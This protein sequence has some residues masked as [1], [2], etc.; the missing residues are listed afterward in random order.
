MT[1]R[2]PRNPLWI[3]YGGAPSGGSIDTDFDE[4]SSFL[5]SL[6]EQIA[7][8]GILSPVPVVASSY[9][10]GDYLHTSSFEV[11]FGRKQP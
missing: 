10:N 7:R 2:N 8:D 4:A 11:K 1:V 5:Y 6:R 9:D 3:M